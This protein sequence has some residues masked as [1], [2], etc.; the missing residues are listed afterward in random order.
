MNQE[1]HNGFNALPNAL[2]LLREAA[3]RWRPTY[4]IG[5][6]EDGRYYVYDHALGTQAVLPFDGP[7]VHLLDS[8]LD[9]SFQRPMVIFHGRKQ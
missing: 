3:Q 5:Q 8:I 2:A 1:Q 7:D 4:D 6:T 9:G